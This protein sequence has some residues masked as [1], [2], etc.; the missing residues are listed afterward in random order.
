MLDELKEE[1]IVNKVGGRFKLSTLIQKRLV[2]I[3]RGGRP[4]VD[5][6]SDDKMEIVIQEILQ[7]KIYLTQ[8]GEL[9]IYGETTEQGDLLDLDA[10][11]L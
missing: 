8:T 3:N 11:D 7:D 10:G 4:L 9:K 6:H 1:A 5:M 2:Q